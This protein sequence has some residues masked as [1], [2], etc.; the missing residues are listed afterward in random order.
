MSDTAACDAESCNQRPDPRC[1]HC[2]GSGRIDVSEKPK[3]PR[4]GE[5]L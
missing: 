1:P 5:L 2:K 4:Q 3:K